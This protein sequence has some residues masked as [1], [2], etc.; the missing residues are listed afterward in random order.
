MNFTHTK[1]NSSTYLTRAQ[2]LLRIQILIG[3]G[4][5]H[6]VLAALLAHYLVEPRLQVF[7]RLPIRRIVHQNNSICLLIKDISCIAV[8][9]WAANVEK[10][11][12]KCFFLLGG[13]FVLVQLHLDWAADGIGRTGED[14]IVGDQIDER[15]LADTCKWCDGICVMIWM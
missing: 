14:F 8:R 11:D 10:F 15:W 5:L 13:F 9:Q 6:R 1:T 7:V 2:K 12:E 4:R 3:K